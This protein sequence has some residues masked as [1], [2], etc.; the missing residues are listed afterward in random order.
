MIPGNL[1]KS[2]YTRDKTENQ[3]WMTLIFG[4]SDY[5]K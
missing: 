5:I 1:E 2:L 4:P 3:Y